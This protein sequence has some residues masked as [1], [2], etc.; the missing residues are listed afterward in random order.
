[1]KRRFKI[2]VVAIPLLLLS[3]LLLRSLVART[4]I[5]EDPIEHP[6]HLVIENWSGDEELFAPAKDFAERFDVRDVATIIFEEL[7]RDTLYRREILDAA[8]DG[9]FDTTQLKLIRVP[10][11]EPKTLNIAAAVIDSARAWGWKEITVATAEL[12]SA[13]SRKT[14]NRAAERYGISVHVRG[15]PY[16]KITADNWF[17]SVRGL[18]SAVE[19]LAKRLYYELAVF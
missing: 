6:K 10:R 18:L 4:I 19:E 2:L 9:G 12:H 3:L 17:K 13:R 5:G 16:S 15:L 14:Y 1:M 11:H 7:Y 8:W